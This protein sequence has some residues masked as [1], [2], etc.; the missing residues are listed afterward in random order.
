MC[1]ITM[2]P[3]HSDYQEL[4]GFPPP[5]PT[6]TITFSNF[7]PSFRLNSNTKSIPVFATETTNTKFSYSFFGKNLGFS[8][9]REQTDL[10]C[11][12]GRSVRGKTIFIHSA[13]VDKCINR[14]RGLVSMSFSL[15]CDNQQY[16]VMCAMAI[17]I[18]LTANLFPGYNYAPPPNGRYAMCDARLLWR[19]NRSGSDSSWPAMKSSTNCSASG[20]YLECGLG[21]QYVLQCLT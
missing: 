21:L 18:C 16:S 10:V 2:L 1:S 14:C 7:A 4:P 12:A 8:N 17:S 6:G 11:T 5:R 13:Q 9:D 19:T 20:S 15:V 3:P